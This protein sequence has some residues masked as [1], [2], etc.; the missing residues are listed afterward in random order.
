MALCFPQLVQDRGLWVP[1]N[2]VSGFWTTKKLIP[3]KIT[4]HTSNHSNQ[5][6][7]IMSQLPRWRTATSPRPWNPSKVLAP[8]Q[9]PSYSL[10]PFASH[11]RDRIP[12][13]SVVPNTTTSS[14]PRTAL[15]ILTTPKKPSYSLFP[16]WIPLLWQDTFFPTMWVHFILTSHITKLKNTY[17]CTQQ[18]HTPT[19]S[20][21]HMPLSLYIPSILFIP[22]V[23]W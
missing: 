15:N 14:R 18:Y 5:H 8:P 1:P 19:H 2:Y 21:R 23:T 12:R 16:F 7:P 4:S 9:T 17:V 20:V 10:S 22:N 3:S 11:G 6:P 13:G